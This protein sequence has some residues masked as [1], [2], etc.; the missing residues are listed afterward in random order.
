ML[1]VMRNHR[2]AAHGETAGYEGLS[3]LPVPLDLD[4]VV[5][6]DLAICRQRAWDDAVS[7]ARASASATRSPPSSHPPARSAW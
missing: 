7:S 4:A 1:R 3:T 6:T 5:N 2:R